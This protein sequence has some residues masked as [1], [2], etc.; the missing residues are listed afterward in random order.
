[1]GAVEACLVAGSSED[2]KPQLLELFIQ[3][4]TGDA[5]MLQLR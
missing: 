5:L 1:M 4:N 2:V 3:A